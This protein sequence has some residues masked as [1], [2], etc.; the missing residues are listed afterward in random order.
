MKSSDG[1]ASTALRASGVRRDARSTLTVECTKDSTILTW[2]KYA[3]VSI[4]GVMA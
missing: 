3:F 4:I 1:A 2:Q